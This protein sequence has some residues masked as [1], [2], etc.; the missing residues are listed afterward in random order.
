[1]K[2]SY[3]NMD[4]VRRMQEEA[5]RRVQQMQ[6][7]AKKSLEL[8]SFTQQEMNK[9]NIENDVVL[10]KYGLKM[11]NQIDDPIYFQGANYK[12][13]YLEESKAAWQEMR[14]FLEEIF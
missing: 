14:E 7:K 11:S 10:G 6:Q 3:E 4:D 1:M 13:P 8:A 9:T 12:E 5:I 2:S